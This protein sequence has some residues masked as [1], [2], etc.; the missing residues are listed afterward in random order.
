MKEVLKVFEILL[1]EI[2]KI[3]IVRIIFH[4]IVIK[5]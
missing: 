4:I 5:I 2:A 3:R 1:M